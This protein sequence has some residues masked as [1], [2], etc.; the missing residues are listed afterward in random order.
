MIPDKKKKMVMGYLDV[1]QQQREYVK[2][3]AG[4]IRLKRRSLTWSQFALYF[5][6]HLLHD[7]SAVLMDL[8]FN[9]DLNSKKVMS[10]Y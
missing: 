4:T 5:F 6:S 1:P 9:R 3:I 10:G 8:N 2:H 7:G